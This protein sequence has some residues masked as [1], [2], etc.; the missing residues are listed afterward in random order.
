MR[1]QILKRILTIRVS[2]NHPIVRKSTN[3]SRMAPLFNYPIARRDEGI[4]ETFFGKEVR[5]CNKKIPFYHRLISIFI[6]S[7]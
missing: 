5:F 4:K 2:I 6:L 7:L 3:Y 1:L